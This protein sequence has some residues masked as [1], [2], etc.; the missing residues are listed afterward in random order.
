MWQYANEG[1]ETPVYQ[2]EAAEHVEFME[3]NILHITRA[4][5]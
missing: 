1:Y 5:N 4:W 2:E 3:L